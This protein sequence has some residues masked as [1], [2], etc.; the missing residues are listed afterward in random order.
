M[1]FGH[2]V[3]LFL[4][5]ALLADAIIGDPKWLWSRFPHP[6]VFAGQLINCLDQRFNNATWSPGT[7]WRAGISALV[8]L[9]VVALGF[10]IAMRWLAG[11]FPGGGA[12]EILIVTILLA[13]RSLYDHVSAV[14]AAFNKGGTMEARGAVAM[15]VGRNTEALDEAGISRASIESA[16]ENLSDGVIAPAFWYLIAGLPGLAI[17]KIV[18]TADSMIGHQT[19]RHEAFGWAAAR[20]DDLLN[21]VPAR[22]TAFLIALSAPLAGGSIYRAMAV[23]C[24]DARLH[25]SPNAGWPEAAMASA[26]GLALG[27]PRTYGTNI[28]GEHWLHKEGR[29]N[30]N[31]QDIVYSLRVLIGACC[32]LVGALVLFLGIGHWFGMGH[33]L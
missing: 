27:G 17:Y 31:Q 7:R 9:M 6:V 19:P 28:L 5:I 29:H 4:L 26:L 12:L 16:A 24:R 10:G 22:I 30:A 14:V 32:L 11:Q 13:P 21:W 20:F 3:V 15:I 8:F 1:I 2:H 25:R 33:W 23:A 18:N